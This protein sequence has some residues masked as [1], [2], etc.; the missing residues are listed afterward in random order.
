MV[1]GASANASA[2]TVKK[3]YFGPALE[4]NFRKKLP[5]FVA[6][7]IV[8]SSYF[9]CGGIPEPHFFITLLLDKY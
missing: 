4:V 9:S 7:Q 2:L 5:Q 1:W 8:Q 6:R 3:N